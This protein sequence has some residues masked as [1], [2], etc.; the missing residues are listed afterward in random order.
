MLSD[1]HHKQF[2]SAVVGLTE[3]LTRAFQERYFK[4][5]K[6]R[7]LWRGTLQRPEGKKV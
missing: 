2:L 5:A 7:G 1:T 4:N 6:T 3:L